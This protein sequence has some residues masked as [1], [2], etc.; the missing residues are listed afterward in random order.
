MKLKGGFLPFGDG[1]DAGSHRALH[2]GEN[3]PLDL[4]MNGDELMC[5]ENLS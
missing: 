2:A 5:L 3:L 4:H 1:L